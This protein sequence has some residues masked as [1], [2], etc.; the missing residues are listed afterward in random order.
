MTDQTKILD[1]LHKRL[2]SVKASEQQG[3]KRSSLIN[4]LIRDLNK[5]EKSP[6]SASVLA[7]AAG[8]YME[9]RQGVAIYLKQAKPRD[10]DLVLNTLIEAAHKRFHDVLLQFQYARNREYSI[11]EESALKYALNGKF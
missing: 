6:T 10:N 8:E 9:L 4:A 3:S 11:A 2:D 1:A 5:I 7:T